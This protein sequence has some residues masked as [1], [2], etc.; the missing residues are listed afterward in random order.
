MYSYIVLSI[1]RDKYTISLRGE[2][3]LILK[4]ERECFVHG[5]QTK[6]EV[7]LLQLWEN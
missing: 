6:V 2:D 1:Y 4:C 5:K 3:I 7:V